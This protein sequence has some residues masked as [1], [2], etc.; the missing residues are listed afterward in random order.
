MNTVVLIL[1]GVTMCLLLV[2]ILS[3]YGEQAGVLSSI[4]CIAVAVFMGVFV[5]K[6]RIEYN[7]NDVVVKVINKEIGY[8]T[9][10]LDKNGKILKISIK[11]LDKDE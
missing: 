5:S 9:L 11:K 4:L 7:E 2:A 10:A 3:K 1:S 6:D 8:D